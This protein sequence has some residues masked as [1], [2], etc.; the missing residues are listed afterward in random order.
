MSVL[1]WFAPMGRV[2]VRVEVVASLLQASLR[3]LVLVD[4]L[5]GVLVASW[6]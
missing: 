3:L 6:K 4:A 1:E 2:L 5:L